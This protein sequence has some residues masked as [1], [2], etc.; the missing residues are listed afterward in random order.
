[1]PTI[2]ELIDEKLA[3]T[4][5]KKIHDTAS[6][7][8]K[9]S[10]EEKDHEIMAALGDAG[11]DQARAGDTTVF[12][13]HTNVPQVT[14][15]EAFYEFIYTNRALHLLERRPAVRAWREEFDGGI[16]LPGTE[17]FEKVTLGKRTT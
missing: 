8:L 4:A 12:I 9:E 11:I 6:Q 5:E 14:D 2:K 10:I 15:W 1:M 16:L 13:Q 7:T 3:L 17:P